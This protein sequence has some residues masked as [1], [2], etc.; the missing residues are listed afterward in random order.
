MATVQCPLPESFDIFFDTSD[1]FDGLL[2][3]AH[4]V[5]VAALP[6]MLHE[7]FT[8]D[9]SLAV[10]AVYVTARAMGQVVSQFGQW[11]GEVRRTLPT[12]NY[13]HD[14]PVIQGAEGNRDKLIFRDGCSIE[15]TL[16][17]F[18][19]FTFAL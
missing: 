9:G 14:A 18:A 17:G 1:S 5:P 4:T 8:C 11:A 12:T 10:S 3:S 2:H 19:H 16:L 13:A 7:G 6:V 15:G